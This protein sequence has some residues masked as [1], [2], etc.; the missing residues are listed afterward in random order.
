MIPQFVVST[1]A[2]LVVVLIAAY[3]FA[4]GAYAIHLALIAVPVLIYLINHPAVWMIWI[5]AFSQSGLIFPGLPQGLQV[6]HALMAGMVGLQAGRL[7][8]EKIGLGRRRGATDFFLIAFMGVLIV[9]AAVRGLGLRALGAETWGGMSYIRLWIVGSFFLLTKALK[10]SERQLV[11]AIYF[12]LAMSLLPAIGQIVFLLSGGKIYQQYLFLEA[13]VGGL[14]SSLQALETGGPVRLHMLGQVSFTMFMIGAILIERRSIISRALYLGV[15]LICV[16]FSALSGFR[17]RILYMLFML[18]VLELLRDGEI[19]FRRLWPVV[20]FLA[21]L[22]PSIYLLSPI[23]PGS[24]QRAFSWLPGIEIPWHIRLEATMSTMNR[25]IVWEMAWNDV[26]RYLWIGKG[27]AIN[28]IELQSPSVIADWV[29]FSYLSHNFHN[30]PLSLLVCTGI[31][32]FVFG[33]LFLVSSCIY[34]ARFLP[35]VKEFPLIRRAYVFLLANHIYSVISFYIV[36]GDVRE[37][38]PP[39]LINLSLMQSILNSVEVEK[40]A[41]Q[42]SRRRKIFATF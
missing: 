11:R 38:L 15:A 20:V 16:T 3:G 18:A 9:T 4:S 32:G 23:L 13:Y 12:M 25:Q 1:L 2:V 6:V 34:F 27:F 19:R 17:G 8:I 31:P 14:V 39:I 35:D 22:T 26:P 36:F 30:G 24:V 21:L 10:L 7:A 41:A 40:V 42:R 37:S 33:T 28:P 29:L 5:Y